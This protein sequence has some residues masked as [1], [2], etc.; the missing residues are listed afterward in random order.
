M[1]DHGPCH[2]S[3]HHPVSELF[4]SPTDERSLRR[5]VEEWR[6]SCVLSDRL[7]DEL[8]AYRRCCIDDTLS[9]SPHRAV[10]HHASRAGCTSVPYI[11][12]CLRMDQ[13]LDELQSASPAMRASFWASWA[14]ITAL[15]GVRPALAPGPALEFC[16][17]EGDDSFRDWTVLQTAASNSPSI[18]L[19][20]PPVTVR[21]DL[22]RSFLIPGSLYSFP[23][24][25]APPGV[26]PG[27]AR[28]PLVL[29]QPLATDLLSKKYMVT[30]TTMA[31]S[32]MEVPVALQFWAPLPGPS[33][34]PSAGID[35]V[36]GLPI[37]PVGG[38]TM[39]DFGTFPEFKRWYAELRYWSV[40]TLF[41]YVEH[42]PCIF[43]LGDGGS[44]A[45]GRIRS[46]PDRQQPAVWLLRRLFD[47]GWVVGSLPA[48]NLHTKGSLVMPALRQPHAH[49][50]YLAAL[51][52]SQRWFE[53]GL[54]CLPAGM[55]ESLYGELLEDPACHK[56]EFL[57]GKD[58][59]KYPHGKRAMGKNMAPGGGG[60]PDAQKCA[61]ATGDGILGLSVGVVLA[62]GVQ[63]CFDLPPARKVRRKSIRGPLSEVFIPD[64][65]GVRCWPQRCRQAKGVLWRAVPA[66]LLRIPPR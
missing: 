42:V 34:P 50:R 11:A 59:A 5:H 48:D 23:V 6:D 56:R 51:L 49:K 65:E 15:P 27:A 36:K 62:P 32:L 2:G 14:S 28:G 1:Y 40:D 52:R 29:V 9:E 39:I 38:P 19:R 54:K 8:R 47:D 53:E 63:D 30:S 31:W 12:G 33:P 61:A 57:S 22:L 66:A 43:A 20:R 37:T 10:K 64:I 16:H 24:A 46:L 21:M 7:A 25:F 45:V 17:R 4:C 13:N 3:K 44:K 41:R 18:L 55:S 60:A 35:A 26:P 58:P